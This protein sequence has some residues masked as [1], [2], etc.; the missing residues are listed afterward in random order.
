MCVLSRHGV[1][2]GFFQRFYAVPLAGRTHPAIAA[3]LIDA[4]V[5]FQGV[6]IRIAKLDGNLTAGAATSLEIDFRV[7]S[8]QTIPSA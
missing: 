7:V 5:D 4:P 8:A 6:I 1:G 2:D 3:D